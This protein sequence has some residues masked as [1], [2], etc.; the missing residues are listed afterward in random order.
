MQLL[1]DKLRQAVDASDLD[2]E[3]AG[4]KAALAELLGQSD[5]YEGEQA[6]AGGGWE[7]AEGSSGAAR[8]RR[9]RSPSLE[10]QEGSSYSS[11]EGA[12]GQGGE[13]RGRRSVSPTEELRSGSRS[14]A[15]EEEDDDFNPFALTGGGRW[16]RGCAACELEWA[17][18][19]F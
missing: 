13:G 11:W 3:Q 5:D 2:R 15:A 9:A 1:T 4:D 18:G 16:G 17:A 10:G 7:D 6:A 8:H 14:P 19:A 12:G